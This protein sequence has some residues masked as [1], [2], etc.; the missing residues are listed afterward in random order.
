MADP[1]STSSSSKNNLNDATNTPEDLVTVCPDGHSCENGSLCIE[2]A[3]KE[4]QYFCDCDEGELA[5]FKVFTGLY[6]QHEATVFC[7]LTGELSTVGF[8]A[9]GGTCMGFLEDNGDN[10]VGCECSKGYTGQHCQ[11]VE[12]SEPTEGY[13]PLDQNS[14]NIQS[15]ANKTETK[16]LGAAGIAVTVLCVVVALG[17]IGTALLVLQRR[18]RLHAETHTIE[19]TKSSDGQLQDADGANLAAPTQSF[20]SDHSELQ[21]SES[22][23]MA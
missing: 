20:E 14:N 6:C 22:A 2:N 21:P 18:W 23:E 19:P 11:F 10:H 16:E 8:C 13:Y 17:M 12:G 15:V 3:L 4:G 1:T 7:T 9:N 5:G